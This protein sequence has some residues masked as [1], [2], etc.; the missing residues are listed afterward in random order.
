VIENMAPVLTRLFTPLFVAVLVAFLVTLL[1]TGRGVNIERNALI[2]FDLLLAVVLGLLLYSM[3]ARDPRSPPGP[4]DWLQ[5]ALVICALLTDPRRALGDRGAHHRV[6]VH[7]E[8][9]R[10]AGRERDLCW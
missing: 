6:W 10:G 5:V 8:P 1:L 7:A 2:A 9:R 4:F 3:S